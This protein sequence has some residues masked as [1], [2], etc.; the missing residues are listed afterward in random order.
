[1]CVEA[2]TQYPFISLV[3]M[4]VPQFAQQQP[5]GGVKPMKQYI[6]PGEQ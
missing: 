3:L 1:M 2:L 4:Y 5:S 6:N